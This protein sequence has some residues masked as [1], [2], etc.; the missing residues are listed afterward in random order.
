MAGTDRGIVQGLLRV[1]ADDPDK[2]VHLRR[3]YAQLAQMYQDETFHVTVQAHCV[4][5]H[6]QEGT[7]SL[8]Y[9]LRFGRSRSIF[10]GQELDD[11]GAVVRL[12]REFP[13]GD[14]SDLSKVPTSFSTEDMAQ[15]FKRNFRH[16]QVSVVRVICLVYAFSL[17]LENIR[18]KKRFSGNY[19]RMLF[20]D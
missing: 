8:Y 13:V 7:Y 15:L 6:D 20:T 17:G 3:A 18:K 14:L 5:R 2:T 4:L 11:E 9:G 12:F 16:S 1:H 19:L 10:L